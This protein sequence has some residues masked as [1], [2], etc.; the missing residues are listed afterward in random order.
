M[1]IQ[2]LFSPLTQAHVLSMA[3]QRVLDLLDPSFPVQRAINCLQPVLKWFGEEFQQLQ[4]AGAE[5]DV[6]ALLGP[7][8]R[9]IPHQVWRPCFCCFDFTHVSSS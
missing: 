3:N 7:L 8:S 6:D 4:T 2:A 9:T 1:L 5:E